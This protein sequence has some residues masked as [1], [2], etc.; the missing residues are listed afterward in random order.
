MILFFLIATALSLSVAWLLVMPS[1]S[2]DFPRSHQWK[3]V[4]FVLLASIV[5]PFSVYCL[6]TF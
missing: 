2:A 5:F 4:C 3:T 6:V 1:L